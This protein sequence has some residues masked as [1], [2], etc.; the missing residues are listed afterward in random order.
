MLELARFDEKG[1]S[2]RARKG[3]ELSMEARQGLE[4]G[5]LDPKEEEPLIL[6]EISIE[7][8]FVDG[9]CGVY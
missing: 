4:A 8:L 5:R 3:G 9:I 7:E 2:N 1:E 6:E